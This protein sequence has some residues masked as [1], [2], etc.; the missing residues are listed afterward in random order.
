MSD[1]VT[2]LKLFVRVARL[3]SFSR[4]GFE[5]GLPQPSV[6]RVIRDLEREVGAA[7]LTRTTR[8]VAL[9]EVGSEYL[10]RIEPILNALEEANHVARGTGELRG[11]L[12][13]G[14]SST[15]A[16]REI[17][18]RLPKFMGRHP[19]L[20]IDLVVDDQRQDLVTEG[21]D[22]ALRL[23]TLSDSTFI[24]RRIAAWPRMLVAS[25]DYLGKAGTPKK[26][27]DLSMHTVIARPG[28]GGASW[29]FRKQGRLASVR[30]SGRLAITLNE[31]AI[32]AA[33]AG[34]GIVSTGPWAC[35]K[36]LTSGALVQVLPDWDMD[37]VEL[38]AL[39][40]AG[41]AAKP[42][43]RVFTEFLVTEF[44]PA[45]PADDLLL[46][47]RPESRRNVAKTDRAETAR[48]RRP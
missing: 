20:R 28:G 9:T 46:L 27:A 47:R 7:L 36:E 48:R 41:R 42:S 13:I 40:A 24:A 12:R 35:R 31:G 19:L 34:L 45:Q 10:A 37:Q 4:A 44:R 39:L 33:V 15:W 38:H 3:A 8:A 11:V 18:P 26:P 32:A 43:A 14:L 1:T 25:P 21:V 5:L 22:V 23:G 6:S 2:A 16:V 30:V 17:I 29:S